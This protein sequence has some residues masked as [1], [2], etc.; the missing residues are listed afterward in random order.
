MI[1]Y[2]GYISALSP[3]WLVAFNTGGAL[4]PGLLMCPGR[5]AVHSWHGRQT[6]S[7]AQ[8]GLLLPNQPSSAHL[9]H[10]FTSPAEWA[11]ALFVAMLSLGE[12]VWS[13]RW[14]GACGAV[15]RGGRASSFESGCCRAQRGFARLAPPPLGT[16]AHSLSLRT[17]L[18]LPSSCCRLLDV[19]GA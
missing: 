9:H 8:Q 12:A 7:L 4:L 10:R 6:R 5:V 11:S 17:A 19:C 1:H 18:A 14:Y 13:P 3:F 2:G 15:A 16:A